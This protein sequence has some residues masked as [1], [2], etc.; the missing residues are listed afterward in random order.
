LQL[1]LGGAFGRGS[2]VKN[3]LATTRSL[4][5]DYINGRAHRIDGNIEQGCQRCSL[6]NEPSREK[7]TRCVS[8]GATKR[9]EVAIWTARLQLVSTNVTAA[10][11]T[12]N[13]QDL[14]PG[15]LSASTL[16][17]LRL[18]FF[19][20]KMQSRIYHLPTAGSQSDTVAHHC[21][22]SDMCHC[23]FTHPICYAANKTD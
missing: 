13:A 21:R 14:G 18:E 19:R 2:G 3:P 23:G 20:R 10:R 1:R 6:R 16:S 8:H 11:R 5:L 17:L 7:Q 9:R 4:D 12:D 15:I 22:I